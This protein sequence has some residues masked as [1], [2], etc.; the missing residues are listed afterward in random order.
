MS[1]LVD[2]LAELTGSRDR[3]VLDTTLAAALRDL[4]DPLSVTMLRCVGPEGAQHWL[5][6]ARLARHDTAASADPVWVDIETLPKLADFPQRLVALQS[7]SALMRAG[8]PALSIFPLA[9][10]REVVGVVEI[11]T[12]KPLSKAAQRTVTSILRVYRNVQ[13]LLDYSERDSLTGLLNRKTFDEAFYKLA[14]AAVKSRD[15]EGDRRTHEPSLAHYVGVIDIDHFK[16]VNDR[17]GHLMGDEVLLLLSRLMRASFRYHDRLFRYGG[18]EFVVLVRCGGD[19]DA[20]VAFERLRSNVQAY[21]F[22]QVGT[23]TVSVGYTVLKPGDTPNLTFERADQAVYWAK[24][25]GRNQVCSHADMAARG[26]AN[27]SDKA[28]AVELF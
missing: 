14:T 1:E 16:T 2:Q 8:S 27:D 21:T 24:R 10:D 6:R 9:T 13:G 28:G 18:E 11:E 20:G 26:E 5:T 15:G 17:F 4:L 12:D 22:P 19:T 23:I 3:D 7:E 25:N